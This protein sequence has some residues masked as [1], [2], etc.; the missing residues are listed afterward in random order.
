MKSLENLKITLQAIFSMST[1]K[2]FLL[3]LRELD[4]WDDKTKR[5]KSPEE[6]KYLTLG[7]ELILY[8]SVLTFGLFWALK[9]PK[10]LSFLVRQWA[11]NEGESVYRSKIS[12]VLKNIN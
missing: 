2:P 7:D 11:G 6:I 4:K 10:K 9:N 1:H 8:L 5:K 12:E 3:S